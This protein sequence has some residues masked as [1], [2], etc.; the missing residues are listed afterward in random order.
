[1]RV[2]NGFPIKE[3]TSF[4][5][6]ELAASVARTA[7]AGLRADLARDGLLVDDVVDLRDPVGAAPREEVWR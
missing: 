1:M 5:L 6:D 7:A 3:W 2:A 4:E